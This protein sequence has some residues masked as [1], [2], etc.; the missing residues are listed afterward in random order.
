MNGYL[1]CSQCGEVQPALSW[2]ETK[3]GGYLLRADCPSCNRFLKWAPQQDPW[4]SAAPM[5]PSDWEPPSP[6]PT[7]RDKAV[8]MRQAQF[9][10]RHGLFVPETRGEASDLIDQLKAGES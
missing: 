2:Q 8:T 6:S 1:S 10:R 3:A 4:L 9:L 5:P 7:W